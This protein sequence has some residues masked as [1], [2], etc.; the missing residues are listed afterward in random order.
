MF[1]ALLMKAIQPGF[2][3]TTQIDFIDQ[4]EAKRE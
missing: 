1:A 3:S 2:C 4:A